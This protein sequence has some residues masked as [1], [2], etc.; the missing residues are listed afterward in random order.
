MIDFEVGDVTLWVSIDS[1][2]PFP[3]NVYRKQG[4]W[5]Y[6]ALCD[7]LTPTDK[8]ELDGLFKDT[9]GALNEVWKPNMKHRL[10]WDTAKIK[11]KKK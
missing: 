6:D 9:L 2:K 1:G 10:L 8:I 4:E 7:K 3:I 11:R 5:Q